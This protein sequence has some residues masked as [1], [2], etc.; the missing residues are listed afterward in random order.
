MLNRIVLVLQVPPEQQPALKALLDS[1]QTKG[2]ASYHAWLTPAEFGQQFGPAPQDLGKMAG[3]LQ[4]EG[5]RV[6][7][8]AQSGL[9]IEFSGTVAQVNAAFHT[10]MHQYSIGGETHIANAT[11]ISV[12]AAMAS[13]TARRARRGAGG[14]RRARWV[15]VLL[16]DECGDARLPAKQLS[17]DTTLQTPSG[18]IALIGQG[19][20]LTG[21]AA[22]GIAT[23]EAGTGGAAST[24]SFTTTSL[25]GGSYSVTA[26][27][28]GDGTRP[29]LQCIR[30]SP[31][32]PQAVTALRIP[33]TTA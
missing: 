5:F 17:S 18:A 4:S 25:P 13:L 33:G 30:C 28:A 3:W 21:S 11:D 15:P 19:G 24:G 12:P 7:G 29:R 23:L 8:A 9:W 20:T 32:C 31:S 6:D 1:Q 22:I 2:S 27:Y 14:I 10:Q 16:H 26:R